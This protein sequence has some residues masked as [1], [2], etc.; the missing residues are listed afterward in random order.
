MFIRNIYYKVLRYKRTE[1]Y[2]LIFEI[3]Y[4]NFINV[5]IKTNVITANVYIACIIFILYYFTL[6]FR[7]SSDIFII[8]FEKKI[9]FKIENDT[10]L[11]RNF[12]S[13]FFMSCLPISFNI[14][15]Y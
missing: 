12:R 15:V 13:F 14:I 5:K 7:N 9:P 8:L 10:S 2:K 4:Y 1:S 3:V 6:Y 11:K